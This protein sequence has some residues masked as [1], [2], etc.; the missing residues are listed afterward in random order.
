MAL[1]GAMAAGGYAAEE[2]PRWEGRLGVGFIVLWVVCWLGGT[3]WMSAKT[4]WVWGIAFLLVPPITLPVYVFRSSL[5]GYPSRR[6][7][8]PTLWAFLGLMVVGAVFAAAGLT[9]GQ[10]VADART[11]YSPIDV[12]D[13]ADGTP[14]AADG[15]ASYDPFA[16]W[17]A[18]LDEPLRPDEYAGD[19]QPD[20]WS[21]YEA[22]DELDWYGLRVY[23]PTE[24]GET[25]FQVYET[26][27]AARETF[28]YY[29]D[30]DP[31]RVPGMP[32]HE[33]VSYTD[34]DGYLT[35]VVVIGNVVL[36]ASSHDEILA[37]SGFG[38]DVTVDGA[39]D[40]LATGAVHRVIRLGGEPNR[41][42]ADY[43]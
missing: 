38:S 13:V 21:D 12:A 33:A 36:F 23:Q 10:Q 22:E 42:P 26:D 14:V 16:M 30:G 15:D 29:A 3:I 32:Q 37:D 34:D 41:N 7:R 25:T 43:L 1:F 40:R 19:D 35:V 17:A 2:A 4:S 8:F 39:V 28:G 31:H 20:R 18:L 6:P 24:M 9:S 27:E 11:P 5:L